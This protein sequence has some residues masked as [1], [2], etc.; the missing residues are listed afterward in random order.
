M[1][2]K[3][4]HHSEST[5][6]NNPLTESDELLCKIHQKEIVFFCR[7]HDKL[8][9]MVCYR[10][11]HSKC[12]DQ[13]FEIEVAAQKVKTSAAMG[14][15][16]LDIL[17]LLQNVKDSLQIQKHNLSS[18]QEVE[19]TIRK[20]VQ[21]IIERIYQQQES[22]L[23]VLKTR[24]DKVKQ[25][26]QDLLQQESRI[27]KLQ[28]RIS[29][30]KRSGTD[31]QLFIEMKMAEEN[32]F[33]ERNSFLEES[34]MKYKIGFQINPFFSSA[35]N[36]L[37]EIKFMS[38]L[39]S[40]STSSSQEA[41]IELPI[42]SDITKNVLKV[43]RNFNIHPAKHLMELYGCVILPNTNVVFI[44]S[45]NKRLVI[46]H[47]NGT[48]LKELLIPGK[49][50]YITAAGMDEV[51]VSFSPR[52][53]SI[54]NIKT[55]QFESKL[56]KYIENYS[57]GICYDDG[58]L[59]FVDHDVGIKEVSID[60]EVVRKIHVDIAGIGNI[61]V[62]KNRIYYT[63][64]HNNKLYCCDTLGKQ[65]WTI[66]DDRLKAKKNSAPLAVD[67]DGNIF[68][69]GPDSGVVIM[70]S[71]DSKQTEVLIDEVNAIR[72]PR[73]LFYDKHHKKLLL[74]YKKNGLAH[75]FRL[76]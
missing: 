7:C 22:F 66:S 70:I 58:K 55:N 68:A 20:E 10:L 48:Y 49:P 34:N 59:Y 71:H 51:A 24:N 69:A 64:D 67:N 56:T 28:E 27:C 1:A 45:S 57:R 63:A 52:L 40:Y 62:Y 19:K 74:C 73:G 35:D 15:L 29:G 41:Q 12:K 26:E 53:I 33:K 43:E 47:E 21:K 23:C 32:A 36:T 5:F 37:G 13:I 6:L 65:I 54:I 3:R 4:G 61:A 9:C 75:L 39:R 17:D 38:T 46:H 8:L 16:E 11:D 76:Q 50:F 25:A 14:K 42:G 44:D 30:L 72:H 2:E 18:F 31:K 60:K